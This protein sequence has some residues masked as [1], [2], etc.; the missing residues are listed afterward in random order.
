L[1]DLVIEPLPEA[2]VDAGDPIDASPAPD[3]A[4]AEDA[5]TPPPPGGALFTSCAQDTDCQEALRCYGSGPG[6]CGDYC[7]QSS[8]CTDHGGIDF[9][10]STD[11]N[12]CRVD[13]SSAGSDGQCPA[14]LT[15]IQSSGSFRCRLPSA[16]GGGTRKRFESCDRAL[17]NADCAD[18]LTC[19]RSVDS[20]VDGPGYCTDSCSFFSGS[21]DNSIGGGTQLACNGSVCRFTC[22]GNVPCPDGMECEAADQGCH[23]PPKP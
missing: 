8:D 1:P 10:C 11:E 2:A 6:Y 16:N 20:Q 23:F 4:P 7:A 21:C 3:A 17:G 19:Y 9:T 22:S 15:C 18:G 13:C 14:P 12:A 5:T